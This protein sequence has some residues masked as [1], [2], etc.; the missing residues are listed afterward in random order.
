M[1][2]ISIEDM[3]KEHERLMNSEQE[4]H[5]RYLEAKSDLDYYSAQ[6]K[7]NGASKSLAVDI[8][9]VFDIDSEIQ[10]P[11]I[12]SYTT[13]PTNVNLTVSQE[14]IER[15]LDKAKAASS[16]VLNIVPK[17]I[18]FMQRLIDKVLGRLGSV[19]TDLNRLAGSSKALETSLIA[20]D[21]AEKP[22]ELKIKSYLVDNKLS[23]EKYDFYK[24]ASASGK[25]PPAVNILDSIFKEEVSKHYT[26]LLNDHYLKDDKVVS[27]LTAA[28]ETLKDFIP[29]LSEKIKNLTT[30][31][32]SGVINDANH[33]RVTLLEE[34]SIVR[35]L[36]EYKTGKDKE[37]IDALKSYVETLLVP[38]DNNPNYLRVVQ[39]DFKLDDFDSFSTLFRARSKKL[40]ASFA[41]LGNTIKGIDG[42][43]DK[44]LKTKAD[45]SI[46][47]L[48]TAMKLMST[49]FTLLVKLKISF[50]GVIKALSKSEKTINKLTKSLVSVD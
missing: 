34:E 44:E 39:L 42:K 48:T 37:G 38:S 23:Y 24:R 32:K 33:Y 17:I 6:L 13:L 40:E 19:K 31:V 35:L 22:N 29:L 47:Y 18:S 16:K 43:T 5:K 3:F 30:E 46:S 4:A 50:T 1:T 45:L 12:E 8:Q 27:S 36:E 25:L 15:Y 26:V 11:S 28:G 14:R 7:T 21:K 41:I 10:L 9:R 49:V 2:A 20:F